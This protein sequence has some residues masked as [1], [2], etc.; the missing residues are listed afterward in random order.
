MWTNLDK[1]QH[2]IDT[3]AEFDLQMTLPKG[4]PILRAVSLGN[5]TRPDNIFISSSLC[6]AV[7]RCNTVPEDRPARKAHIPIVTVINA[8]PE[9]QTEAPR[10]NY[11]VADWDEVR[12]E[13]ALR[14]EQLDVHEDI[15]TVASSTRFWTS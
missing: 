6:L 14:L 3:T 12:L 10:T 2:L 15:H 7:V 8:A 9:V 13:M 4:L 5:Y 1:A 11:R